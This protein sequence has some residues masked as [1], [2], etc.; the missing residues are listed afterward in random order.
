MKWLPAA[1]AEVGEANHHGRDG[2]WGIEEQREGEADGRRPARSARRCQA[3]NTKICT[4]Q[5]R[6]A[7]PRQIVPSHDAE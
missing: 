4:R 3:H 7:L 1:I 6:Y 5:A 2:R